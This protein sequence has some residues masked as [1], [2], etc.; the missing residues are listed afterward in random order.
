MGTE[1]EGAPAPRCLGAKGLSWP[2]GW[3]ER[4]GLRPGARSPP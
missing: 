4:K 3:K 1:G 2:G